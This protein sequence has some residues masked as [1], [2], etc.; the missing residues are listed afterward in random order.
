M[1]NVLKLKCSVCERE[2]GPNEVQYTCP[3][4]GDVGTLDVLYDYEQLRATLERDTPR[5]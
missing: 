1:A 2:Y 5:S 4:C 3:V